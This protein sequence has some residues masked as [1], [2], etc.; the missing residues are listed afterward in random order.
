MEGV[1]VILFG[2]ALFAL[3][4]LFYVKLIEERREKRPTG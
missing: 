1:Y 3:L 2:T 4:F